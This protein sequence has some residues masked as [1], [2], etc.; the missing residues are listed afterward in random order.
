MDNESILTPE[1]HA[2]LTELV[3]KALDRYAADLMEKN[4]QVTMSWSFHY[5]GKPY[6]FCLMSADRET[7]TVGA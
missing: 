1:E 3:T 4:G 2:Q 7:H 5:D 6:I